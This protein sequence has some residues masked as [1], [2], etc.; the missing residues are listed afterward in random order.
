[1]KHCFSKLLFIL[2]VLFC[3]NCSADCNCP[4]DEMRFIP[5]PK[6]YVKPDQVD[7]YENA[8]FVQI[9]DVIIQAESLSTDDQG[10]FFFKVKEKECG[11][12]QWKCTNKGARGMPCDTCNWTWNSTCSVCGEGKPR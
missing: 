1:M 12:S 4:Q 2:V 7:F 6:T 11:V 3:V 8:I 5:C 9:N 10:I